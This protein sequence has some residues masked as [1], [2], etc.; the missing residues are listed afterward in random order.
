MLVNP[1]PIPI[2]HGSTLNLVMMLTSVVGFVLLCLGAFLF[3]YVVVRD[4]LG[5]SPP[6]DRK[7]VVEYSR[8]SRSRIGGQRRTI[9]PQWLMLMRSIQSRRT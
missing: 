6:A 4:R 5:P 7:A 8:R 3:L 1:R 2:E 9:E